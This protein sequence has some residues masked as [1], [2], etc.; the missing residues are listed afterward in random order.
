[1]ARSRVPSLVD[2]GTESSALNKNIDPAGAELR[3][4]SPT[5]PYAG[6]IP[7]LNIEWMLPGMLL[8]PGTA[9]SAPHLKA[10][11]AAVSAVPSLFAMPAL[12]PAPP[13]PAPTVAQVNY[14]T[15]YDLQPGMTSMGGFKLPV[16]P[17]RY[18]L[19]PSLQDEFAKAQEA[20]QQLEQRS[21]F[22]PE[23]VGGPETRFTL[24]GEVV[25]E[26]TQSFHVLEPPSAA[27]REAARLLGDPAFGRLNL[28]WPTEETLSAPWWAGP[29]TADFSVASTATEV[30]WYVH[31]TTGAPSFT[32]TPATEAATT[33]LSPTISSAMQP[34]LTA[35]SPSLGGVSQGLGV[36]LGLAQ[37]Y[38]LEALGENN[39]EAQTLYNAVSGFLVG[40]PAGAA[41]AVLIPM[42]VEAVSR[43]AG[44]GGQ[45]RRTLEDLRRT[46][47]VLNTVD[48]INR[49]AHQGAEPARLAQWLHELDRMNAPALL[50]HLQ[51]TGR[52]PMETVSLL[53]KALTATQG[54][55]QQLRTASTPAE[56]ARAAAR[57]PAPA[58]ITP[59][60]IVQ[61]RGGTLSSLYYAGRDLPRQDAPA[62]YH[63][64]SNA[65]IYTTP[66]P[67]PSLEDI[68]RRAETELFKPQ[69]EVLHDYR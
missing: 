10:A 63:P 69:V 56:I 64:E 37:P 50:A 66:A 16:T 29:G 48:Y 40:G 38:I 14:P 17:G 54:P 45:Q 23:T 57:L 35:I 51:R 1:M 26:T 31:P 6:R 21:F 19:P 59:E 25:P 7:S 13:F 36:A 4:P 34:G 32:V 8:E 9:F 41:L 42:A 20:I 60:D 67:T 27:V 49:L 33:T 58:P 24:E 55:F 15:L 22:E 46:E 43:L 18:E 5:W 47:G 61:G 44:A 68:I 11:Q 12:P 53:E 65:P 3:G 52:L 39:R 28:A 62:Y 30:P 2:P